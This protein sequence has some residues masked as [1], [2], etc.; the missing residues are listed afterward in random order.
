LR[1]QIHHLELIYPPIT[2][3]QAEWLKNSEETVEWLKRSKLYFIAQRAECKF[4]FK[5]D[6]LNQLQDNRIINFYKWEFK[7][8][9]TIK[10]YRFVI[11]P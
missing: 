1:A 4:Q 11:I 6:V 8:R 3:Q 5:D 9:G 7:I 2:N 10:S